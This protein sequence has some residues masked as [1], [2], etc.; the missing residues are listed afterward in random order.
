[1]LG[2]KD[3]ALIYLDPLVP[4]FPGIPHPPISPQ[5]SGI[6]ICRS[7]GKVPG[8]HQETTGICWA[9][10]NLWCKLWWAQTLVSSHGCFIQGHWRNPSRRRRRK[11]R[12]PRSSDGLILQWASS[13]AG[14]TNGYLYHAMHGNWGFCGCVRCSKP[15]NQHTHYL[16]S[17][18]GRFGKVRAIVWA[19]IA[20][21]THVANLE[22]FLRRL[23]MRKVKQGLGWVSNHQPPIFHHSSNLHEAQ[24]PKPSMPGYEPELDGLARMVGNGV[25]SPDSWDMPLWFK[26]QLCT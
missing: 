4:W 17:I 18:C 7:P 24:L 12:Q 23:W 1:M 6:G 9:R 8:P 22:C 3:V 13:S 5:G 26:R 15:A 21:A 2:Q 19:H 10:G 25:W 14:S 20:V 11:K 16:Q